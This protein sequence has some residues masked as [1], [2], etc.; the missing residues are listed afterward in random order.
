MMN[1][2]VCRIISSSLLHFDFK[3]I[4]SNEK[5]LQQ[6]TRR[7]NINAQACYVVF[8][9]WHLILI[10]MD[11]ASNFFPFDWTITSGKKHKLSGKKHKMDDARYLFSR[12]IA[13]G[14]CE[15]NAHSSNFKNNLG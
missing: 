8:E 15:R 3:T 11:F 14:K 4:S 13:Y 10:R 6:E 7:I 12:N 9:F 1:M 2:H 5:Q